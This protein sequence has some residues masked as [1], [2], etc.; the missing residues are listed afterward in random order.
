M[1]RHKK[2][3]LLGWNIEARTALKET[4]FIMLV[5]VSEHVSHSLTSMGFPLNLRGSL[6]P[7]AVKRMETVSYMHKNNR[8]ALPCLTF[9]SSMT[10]LPVWPPRL[11]GCA[12]GSVNSG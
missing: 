9:C 3:S 5:K 7:I 4:K 10:I 1:E 8:E 12:L 6:C 11:S 2:W